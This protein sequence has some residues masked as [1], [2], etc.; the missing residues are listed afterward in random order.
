MVVVV[1]SWLWRRVGSRGHTSFMVFVERSWRCFRGRGTGLVVPVVLM[2]VALRS[3]SLS[4]DRGRDQGVF[5]LVV[6]PLS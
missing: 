1:A 3:C 4:R 6:V 2:A 5:I